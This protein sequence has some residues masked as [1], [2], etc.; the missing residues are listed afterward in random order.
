MVRA[1]RIAIYRLGRSLRVVHEFTD[2]L[3]SLRRRVADEALE[4]QARTD[5][6]N[7][8]SAARDSALLD[9]VVSPQE[10]AALSDA[11]D[12]ARIA[13]E[14]YQSMLNENRVNLTLAS[15]EALGDHLAGSPGRKSVVWISGGVPVT[16]LTSTLKGG[17]PLMSRDR[18]IRAA[19]QRL[20]S[21]GSLYI[22]WTR[23][24]SSPAWRVK[25]R[26]RRSRRWLTWP[27]AA[28][29]RA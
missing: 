5:V 20:A 18:A 28:R 21:Q 29:P 22:R 15:L 10:R 1:T 8:A 14:Q 11:L 19:A 3:E 4:M 16:W 23:E 25:A 7:E 26:T 9:N 6:D 27:G 24:V 13:E 2:D 12:A 17:S